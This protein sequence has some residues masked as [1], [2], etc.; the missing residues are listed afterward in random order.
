[1]QCVPDSSAADMSVVID[2]SGLY[3]RCAAE[4]VTCG[5]CGCRLSDPGPLVCFWQTYQ[6]TYIP[7][8]EEVVCLHVDLGVQYFM[9]FQQKCLTSFLFCRVLLYDM[10]RLKCLVFASMCVMCVDNL[11]WFSSSTSGFQSSV[12]SALTEASCWCPV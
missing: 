11:G 3:Q 10:C 9:V 8:P 2:V 12:A 1:M 5:F 4:V 7:T 6:L